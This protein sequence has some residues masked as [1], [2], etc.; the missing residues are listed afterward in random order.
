MDRSRALATAV[1]LVALGACSV[2]DDPPSSAP[3]S[4]TDSTLAT[5]GQTSPATADEPDNEVAVTECYTNAPFGDTVYV[6]AR[7]TITNATSKASNYMIEVRFLDGAGVQFATGNAFGQSV[8]P[9][10]SAVFDTGG[11]NAL[12]QGADAAAVTCQLAD[13][14]RFAA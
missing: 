5:A 14:T 3:I 8:L 11:Y 1:A 7:G 9:G 6:G 4:A 10:G 13:V 12:P 2:E